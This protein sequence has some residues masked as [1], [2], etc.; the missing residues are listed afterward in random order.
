MNQNLVVVDPVLARSNGSHIKGKLNVQLGRLELT[1]SRIIFYGKSR[2]FMM[3]GVLGALLSLLAKG[4]RSLDV[5]LGQ[6]A[7]V[8]RGKFGFNKKILEVTMLDGTQHRL[9]VDKL[10]VFAAQL[11]EQLARCGRADAYRMAS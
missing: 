5:E 7:A 1:S 3:F 8:A 6:V 10:D 2:A 4:T 11:R 9:G